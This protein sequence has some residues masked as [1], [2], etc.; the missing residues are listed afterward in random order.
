[1]TNSIFLVAG[2]TG[3]TGK[4]TVKYLREAGC[5]VRAMVHREDERSAAL[6]ELGAEVVAGDLLDL[7]S[8]R[9]GLEGAA[10]AY[11]VYPIRPGLLYATAAFGQAA[12]EAGVE[13]IVNLS[14]MSARR[15]APS[16]ASREHWLGER[17]LD[18]SGMSV[19]HLRPTLFA[20]WFIYR[21]VAYSIL[22]DGK[23]RVPFDSAR[24]APIAAEDQARLIVSI[25]Q[26]PEPHRGG[27]YDLYGPVEGTHAEHAEAIGRAL[28]RPVEFEPMPH[29]AIR[30]GITAT[31]PGA[32]HLAQHL[33][34]IAVDYRN[35][36][37]S[38]T[39]DVIERITG[40][41]PMTVEAFIERNAEQL[42]AAAIAQADRVTAAASA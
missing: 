12:R 3:P 34:S 27:I 11:F 31:Y 36:I 37:F 35:G 2:A 16:N 38:G 9:V 33:E 13:T 23:L 25:L 20:E 8:V 42:T 15:D 28:G 30:A 29:E 14:Q 4:Y 22:T 19:T 32:D 39:N 18:R 7:E 41:P 26:D 10:G 1:M 21:P 17:M 24:H 6:A 40:E 5:S